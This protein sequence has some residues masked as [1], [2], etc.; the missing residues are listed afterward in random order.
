MT[1][2]ALVIAGDQ[3]HNPMFTDRK[4]WRS[5]A[6]HRSP[7]NNKALLTL[8]GAEHGL[9]GISGYDAGETT[10]ENPE[11]VAA[12]RALVWAY[13]QSALKQDDQA[14]P[15]A[16]AL[17]AQLEPAGRIDSRSTTTAPSL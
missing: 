6:Y 17:A 2:Q 15:A 3:D 10:D 1:K 16:A 5:D 12:V 13:L 9:G 4:D 14:W 11:R 7:G 8:F